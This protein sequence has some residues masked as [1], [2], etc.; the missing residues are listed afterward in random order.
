MKK[1][2]IKNMEKFNWNQS[3]RYNWYNQKRSFKNNLLISHKSLILEDQDQ[4]SYH[5]YQNSGFDLIYQ[6]IIYQMPKESTQYPKKLID[7]IIN[8]DNGQRFTLDDVLRL[9]NQQYIYYNDILAGLNNNHYKYLIKYSLDFSNKNEIKEMFNNL[10]EDAQIAIK[11]K[12]INLQVKLFLQKNK[13]ANAVTRI[14]NEYNC[15]ICINSSKFNEATIYHQ[16]IH[17]L[18]AFFGIL[19]LKD[20]NYNIPINKI[21]N[22]IP[23]EKINQIFQDNEI[24]PNIITFCLAIQDLTN[25]NFSQMIKL[26]NDIKENIE[27]KNIYFIYQ[28][29][30]KFKETDFSINGLLILY[31]SY[32]E[33]K[34]LYEYLIRFIYSYFEKLKFIDKK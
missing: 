34:K 8:A 25:S 5:R 18:Q 2:L 22:N 26:F 20:I 30:Q 7:T 33:V 3:L 11:Q 16:F 13:N 24:I 14:I 4:I 10:Y 31:L 17:I 6:S 1:K 9:V 29:I 27:R 21:F 28:E 23:Q 12:K 15:L 19:F 32:L